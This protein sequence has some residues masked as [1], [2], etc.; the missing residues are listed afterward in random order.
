MRI[1]Y[2]GGVEPLMS[3]MYNRGMPDNLPW[4]ADWFESP[5]Q[6]NDYWANE[7]KY[8]QSIRMGQPD[9]D[10]ELYLVLDRP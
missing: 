10:G 7:R 2:I 6:E 3:A 8:W 1:Y 5:E 9:D 4:N